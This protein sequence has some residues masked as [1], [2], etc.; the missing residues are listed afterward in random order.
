MAEK[1]MEP[2]SLLHCMLYI[3]G[4]EEEEGNDPGQQSKKTKHSKQLGEQLNTCTVT[5]GNV[6]L[7]RP[8]PL[9]GATLLRRVW[10]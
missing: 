3:V 8:Q 10:E 2:S 7:I 9:P 1:Q 5:E 6:L 4:R